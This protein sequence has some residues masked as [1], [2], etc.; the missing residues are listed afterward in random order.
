MRFLTLA[1]FLGLLLVGISSLAAAEERALDHLYSPAMEEKPRL[2]LDRVL[3][4]ARNS[5][6]DYALTLSQSLLDEVD[7]MRRG[8]PGVYGQLLVN[9]GI[10]QSAD[11]EY[12]LSLPLIENGLA[13]MEQRANPFSQSLVNALMA[14]GLTM[15]AADDMEGAEDR[16]SPGPAHHAPSRRRLRRGPD[17]G[18]RLAHQDQPEA[19]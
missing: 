16:L 7:P 11:G 19:G 4:H 15:F 12:E 9:H 5:E 17:P 1:R 2:L 6:Y 3:T 14:R 18:H 10:I 8:A 13:L